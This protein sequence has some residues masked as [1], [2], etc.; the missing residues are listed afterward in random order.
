MG[1][2]WKGLV[3]GAAAA[4]GLA[5]GGAPPELELRAFRDAEALYASAEL[6][7]LPGKDLARVVD[8]SFA[9]R[10]KATFRAGRGAVEAY[11]DL[12]YDGLSYRVYVSETGTSH[13]T[14]DAKAAWAIASRFSR[15]RL[16]ELGALA[17]PLDLGCKVILLLPSDP[18]YDPMV[19]WGYKPAAA[20]A[21][22]DSP[23]YVPY[24]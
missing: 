2:W 22:L 9:L 18:G 17:F 16:A 4:L 8:S 19:V 11:R 6:L 3:L 14:A 12:R 13:T 23:A 5:P 20:I 21:E 24:Y 7:D 10:V 1:A 15:I